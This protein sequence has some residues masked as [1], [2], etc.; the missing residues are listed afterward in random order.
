FNEGIARWF[1]DP[2]AEE[3][4]FFQKIVGAGTRQVLKVLESLTGSGFIRE[5]ADFFRSIEGWQDRLRERTGAVHRL[6]VSDQ[7]EFSLVTNFDRA[8]LLESETLAKEIRRGGYRLRTVLINR[9][10][11]QWFDASEAGPSSGPYAELYGRFR[12]FYGNREKTIRD[13][14]LRL[15][16]EVQVMQLPELT[17]R[18]YDLKGLRQVAQILKKGG[19]S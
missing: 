6:L 18:V 5:L 17:E 1:R 2:K 14:S 3:T 9:A 16:G 10:F 12:D 13:F 19:W 7:A 11:P 15:K 4:G 8:K